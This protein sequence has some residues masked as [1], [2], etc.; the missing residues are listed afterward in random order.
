M[1]TRRSNLH[2]AWPL[3]VGAVALHGCRRDPPSP[4]PSPSAAP[5]PVPVPTASSSTSPLPSSKPATNACATYTAALGPRRASYRV[6][7]DPASH[8]GC[9]MNEAGNLQCSQDFEGWT[10]KS[11]VVVSAADAR[12]LLDD[13]ERAALA[14]ECAPCPR[15]SSR[16]YPAG[17][18]P[19]AYPL[20]LC[21]RGA[22]VEVCAPSVKARLLDLRTR[23]AGA[24]VA[25][26]AQV[27]E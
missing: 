15:D 17:F 3:L 22:C 16:T 24:R 7:G 18:D 19:S 6:P 21:K 26:A 20:R 23:Y 13:A 27:D 14:T 2:A 10:P 8:P 12:A 9:A 4:S 1:R 25:T 5:A 11:K